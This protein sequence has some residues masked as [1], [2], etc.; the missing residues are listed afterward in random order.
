MIAA[1][2][3]WQAAFDRRAKMRAASGP[4]PPSPWS[5][6]VALK[7]ATSCLTSGRQR[8]SGFAMKSG[9]REWLDDKVDEVAA[10]RRGDPVALARA[11]L[12]TVEQA[13]DRYLAAHEVDPATTDSCDGS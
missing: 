5:E 4:A 8:A 9:A 13:V 3:W 12:I 7:G 10:L 6:A 11:E 2:L 1:C